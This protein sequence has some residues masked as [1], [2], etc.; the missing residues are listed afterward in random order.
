MWSLYPHTPVD[1]IQDRVG[2][3]MKNNLRV[4]GGLSSTH[5]P[6]RRAGIDAKEWSHHHL[7]P[8]LDDPRCRFHTFDDWGI[9]GEQEHREMFNYLLFQMLN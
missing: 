3:S 6:A 7:Q 5:T 1:V 9:V 2:V 4:C 8:D